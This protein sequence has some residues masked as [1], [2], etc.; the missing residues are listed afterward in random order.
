M[1]SK[2][3][4]RV[5]SFYF[6]KLSIKSNSALFLSTIWAFQAATIDFGIHPAIQ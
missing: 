1:I 6:N 3:V 2:F 5:Q 4:N